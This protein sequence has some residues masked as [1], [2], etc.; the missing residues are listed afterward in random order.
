MSGICSHIGSLDRRYR[1]FCSGSG[2]CT[3]KGIMGRSS[4]RCNPAFRKCLAETQ[5]TG[6][7]PAGSPSGDSGPA[8]GRSMSCWHLGGWS[9]CAALVFG[10]EVFK[11]MR[12]PTSSEV[13]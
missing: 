9:L 8:S 1:Y 7:I 11:Y 10:V 13:D 6:S 12:Q 3:S 5:D 4:I 2:D